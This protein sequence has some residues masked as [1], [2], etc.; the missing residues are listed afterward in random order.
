M[1]KIL[2]VL[3]GFLWLGNM[4]AQEN[5]NLQT[6]IM[7]K[8][9][10]LRSALLNKDSVTFSRILSDD[11]TYGHS[12]GLMQ[13]KQELIRSVMS[14]QHEYKSIEPSDMKIRLYDN[15]AVVTAKAKVKL[16]SDGKP[17]DLSMNLLLVWVKQG[18]E[19]KLVA[20]QAVK[21]N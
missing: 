16:N 5:E 21:N 11:L 13:S 17:L 15:T 1:K 9:A 12:I 2:L 18:N 8:M 7:L 10:S 14:G 19:W 20:R 6:L 4:Y 3:M